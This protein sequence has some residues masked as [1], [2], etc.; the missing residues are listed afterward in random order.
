MLIIEINSKIHELE[1]YNK[2]ANDLIY[3]CRWQKAIED[4]LQ[5]LENYQTQEYNKFLP[6]QKAVGSKWVFRVKYHLISAITRFKA[7]PV[8]QFL[9][10]SGINFVKTFALIV[11]KKSLQIYLALC[12][13]HNLFIYEVDII[14]VYLKILPSNNKL[15]IFIKL[16]LK[17]QF[18]CQ[19]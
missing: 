15:S 17:I 4:K 11:K 18:L 2:V 3:G 16:L 9:Q 5:N 13:I 12:L 1:S 6:E 8:T 7:K 14:K 10:I 19:I